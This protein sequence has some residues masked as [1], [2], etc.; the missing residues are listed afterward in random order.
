M[1]FKYLTINILLFSLISTYSFGLSIDPIRTIKYRDAG[2]IT[3]DVIILKNIKDTATAFDISF[4]DMSINNTSSLEWMKIP[5]K[6][7]QFKPNESINLNYELH[8]PEDAKGEYYGRLSFVE[9]DI[10]AD[11]SEATGMMSI[12]TKISVP[13]FIIVNGTQNYDSE[14]VSLR[15]NPRNDKQLEILLHNKGNVHIR[16]LGECN[17]MKEGSE[18]ILNK[19]PIN[20]DAF[21]VYPQTSRVLVV[22]MTQK[23]KPGNYTIDVYFPKDTLG[24]NL[25]GSYNLVTSN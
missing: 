4:R 16:P 12:K 10:D 17:I 2:T 24:I 11:N 15:L 7:V 19:Y 20:S 22:N 23:L 21:P 1:R 25:S 8:I 5:E 6:S 14:L 13:V 9:K 3:N 18:E